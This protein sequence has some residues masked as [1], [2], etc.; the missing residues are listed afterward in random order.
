M[1][2]QTRE[3]IAGNLALVRR[4]IAAACQRAGRSPDEI[5]LIAV[6]KTVS[7]DIVRSAYALGLADVGENRVQEAREKV[8]ALGDLPLRWHMIGHLQ[9]NKAGQ[10]VTLFQM[11]HSVDSVEIAA[12]LSRLLVA[13]RMFLPVLLEV[14]VGGEASK[15]GFRPADVAPAVEGI[16][17]LPGLNVQG[18]MT[19]APLVAAPELGRPYFRQM[20]ALR[21]DLRARYPSESWRHLSMGMTDDFE[22]AIEEGATMIR[23]G[24]AIFGARPG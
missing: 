14:N 20:R 13:K 16:A 24:R 10:T 6:T 8:T 23:L 22:I 21:D 9:S 18:L 19:V 2:N 5:T 4:R 3:Q 7:A 17:A 11:L 15:S 12:R 1:D